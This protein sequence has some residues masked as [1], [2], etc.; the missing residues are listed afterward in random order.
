M[1]I[2]PLDPQEYNALLHFR[3]VCANWNESSVAQT[4]C[5]GNSTPIGIC[6]G[7]MTTHPCTGRILNESSNEPLNNYKQPWFGIKCDP[8]TD[9]VSV[10]EINLPYQSLQ[11]STN[12]LNF[13]SFTNL[14]VLNLEGNHITGSI[15]NW[16]SHLEYL[17]VVNFNYN[18]LSGLLPNTIID[19]PALNELSLNGNSLSGEL[20]S[21]LTIPPLQVFDLGN[22]MFNGTLPRFLFQSSTMQYLD[23]SYNNFSG[24]LPINST[25]SRIAYLDLSFNNLSGALPS[26]LGSF[27]RV[28][29]TSISSLNYFDVSNNHLEMQIPSDISTLD[30][31]EYFSVANNSKLFGRIPKLPRSLYAAFNPLQFE[32]PGVVY[33]PLPIIPNKNWSSLICKCGDGSMIDSNGP[34]VLC[35]PGYF[36]NQSVNQT[37]TLCPN[38]TFSSLGASECTTCPSG[39]FGNNSGASECLRCEL[40]SISN[41]GA[42]SCTPCQPGT[43]PNARGNACIKCSKGMYSTNG[44]TCLP[45]PRGTFTNLISLTQC[46]PC[47]SQTYSLEGASSCLTCPNGTIADGV[48]NAF[49]HAPPSPGMEWKSNFTQTTPCLPGFFNNGSF[50]SCQA[51]PRGTFSNHSQSINC[52]LCQEGTFAIQIASKSCLTAF[53]G[54]IVPTKGSSFPIKCLPGTFAPEDGATQC[55]ICPENSTSVVPG[56]M[57]CGLASPGYVMVNVSLPQLLLTLSVDIKFAV[58]HE[59]EIKALVQ[60]SW[61][62]FEISAPVILLQSVDNSIRQTNSISN[63]NVS[64]QIA[65]DVST[66]KRSE[67]LDNFLFP[68]TSGKYELVFRMLWLRHGWVN[69]SMA[70]K[71]LS[72]YEMKQYQPCPLGSYFTNGYCLQCPAGMYSVTPG[73]L[74]CTPCPVDTFAANSGAST[75]L[76]CSRDTFSPNK[77]TKTCQKCPLFA[78]TLNPLCRASLDAIIFYP[79]VIFWLLWIVYSF[80]YQKFHGISTETEH[81][82]EDYRTKNKQTVNTKHHKL[83]KIISSNLHYE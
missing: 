18:N 82:L 17:E 79:L 65:L 32:N 53:K 21:G 74:S 7:N 44:Q 33:C 58:D 63:G 15:P 13:T 11:C 10:I 16:I 59:D 70:A 6:E 49:C 45:C 69:T 50:T 35:N 78:F 81:L 26:N 73:S 24:N 71:A 19:A 27:G 22:N 23:L 48:G 37:C 47:P 42:N 9:P 41:H 8:M 61:E 25:L 39:T 34:C 57:S 36:S 1:P 80:F 5:D 29:A 43:A 83:P 12:D 68:I 31:L 46:T 76:K 2:F 40:G 30:Q 4:W 66:I 38:G 64:L 67:A 52:D 77:G 3:R 20:V 55:Q 54:T 56:A 75:C 28:E 72:L 62:Y 60:R 51:C 14:Q